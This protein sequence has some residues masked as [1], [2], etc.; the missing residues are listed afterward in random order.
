[1]ANVQ[2]IEFSS[3]QSELVKSLIRNL[4]TNITKYSQQGIAS[5][6]KP[7]AHVGFPSN[8]GTTLQSRSRQ[9]GLAAFCY[10][11]CVRGPRTCDGNFS[12]VKYRS[13]T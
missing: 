5:S 10:K 11:G 9:R 8:A 1:M 13:R 7:V 12:D 3:N 6:D 4:Q 2:G